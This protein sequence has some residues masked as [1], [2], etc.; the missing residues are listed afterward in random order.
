MCNITS[1][2]LHHDGVATQ[3]GLRAVP[4][5]KS[6]D[7]PQK[8]SDARSGGRRSFPSRRRQVRFSPFA[9]FADRAPSSPAEL[10]P[11]TL[12]LRLPCGRVQLAT[13]PAHVSYCGLSERC[14]IVSSLAESES[15][16]PVMDDEGG[17]TPSE[18]RKRI[19]KLGREARAMRILERLRG[20]WDPRPTVF[21]LSFACKPLISPDCGAKIDVC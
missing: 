13:P 20:G 16:R 14:A 10:L 2:M 18:P 15:G 5:G 3:L 9:A 19:R 1:F 4:P 6:Q 12:R 11:P 7:S 17:A 8:K 21:P